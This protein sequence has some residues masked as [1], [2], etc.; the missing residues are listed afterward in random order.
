MKRYFVISKD[1]GKAVWDANFSPTPDAEGR[2]RCS[3]V[4]VTMSMDKKRG[5][6][7]KAKA[8]AA[9]RRATIQEDEE[10]E[11]VPNEDAARC[12]KYG[13]SMFFV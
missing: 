9:A 11:V 10:F 8:E 2:F 13:H 12:E 3:A 7:K 1:G 6:T 4:K 5:F